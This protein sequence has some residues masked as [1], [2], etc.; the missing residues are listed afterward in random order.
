M[1]L[2]KETE[3][4]NMHTMKCA[5]CG[6]LFETGTERLTCSALCARLLTV[7]RKKEAA[8]AKENKPPDPKPKKPRKVRAVP[9][10]EIERIAR[11]EKTSYGNIVAKYTEEELW[12]KIKARKK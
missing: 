10:I 3:A 7:N 6:E 1:R 9:S 4:A 11:D 8:K 2:K 12:E 5:V